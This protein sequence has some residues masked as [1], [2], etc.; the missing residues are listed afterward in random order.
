[1]LKTR[2]HNV[3]DVR[4]KGYD[5]GSNTKGKHQCI[6]KR[7]LEIN[8]RALIY[9]PCVRHSINLTL[10]DM[11]HSYKKAISFFG[12]IQRLYSLLPGSIK[13]WK[14]LLNNV[15]DLTMKYLE[16]SN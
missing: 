2:G 12:V 3:D 9:M 4:E 6:Q 5:N 15:P 8:P 10:D 16:M 14:I 13:R 11:T 1:M 7:F